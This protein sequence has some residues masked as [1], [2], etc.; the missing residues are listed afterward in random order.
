M[1]SGL[2]SLFMLAALAW[3]IQEAQ[4]EV[5][6]VRLVSPTG[7]DTGD[8]T[9]SPCASISYA[10]AQSVAADVIEVAP[11]T[12]TDT[13]NID[14]D[15]EI[16]GTAGLTTTIVQAAAISTTAVS[17][18]I[19]VTAGAE[20]LLD[21]LTLQHGNFYGGVFNENG[22]VTVQNSLIQ[23]NLAN[24]LFNNGHMMTVQNSLIQENQGIGI[25]NSANM[26][27]SDSIVRGNIVMGSGGGILNRDTLTVTRSLIE[28][29]QAPSWTSGG[30]IANFGSLWLLDSHVQGNQSGGGAGLFTNG[31]ALLQN[32]MIVSNTAAN[33]GGG[34]RHDGS[35]L[36]IQNSTIAYN[37]TVDDTF[38]GHGGGLT[39]FPIF[40]SSVTIENST[41]SYNSANGSGGGIYLSNAYTPTNELTV[42]NSTIA[43]NTADA[44]ADGGDG[45]G[46]W[47]LDALVTLQNSMVAANEDGSDGAPDCVGPI[48]SAGYNL[49]GNDAGCSFGAQANDMVG[50][51]GSVIDPLLGPLTDNGGAT[52]TQALLS[53]SPALNVIPNGV[54][55]CGSIFNEDQ[56]GVSRPQGGNCDTGAFEMILDEIVFLPLVI[57]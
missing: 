36:T 33:E 47:H 48:T 45:G 55:G 12:Y 49:I 40:T 9:G 3:L 27:V 8:C 34:I 21:G 43:H 16:V 31:P 13:V 17:P 24:G 29:N 30:G 19:S 26:I 35:D 28:N 11:G 56:R 50:S 5:T 7:S 57:R 20:V 39:I 23:H 52:W 1:V 14:I 42:Y 32:S 4:A 51:S 37:T 54:N 44:D 18:V 15:L 10:V 22:R 25:Q 38:S 41:I 2:F 6:A 46:I 53:G